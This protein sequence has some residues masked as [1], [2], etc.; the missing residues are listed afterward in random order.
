M[1]PLLPEIENNRNESLSST[2]ARC[3]IYLLSDL[4]AEVSGE[5]VKSDFSVDQESYIEKGAA[6]SLI[7]TPDRVW[8][9]NPSIYVK[10]FDY[11]NAP[12]GRKRDDTERGIGLNVSRFFKDFELFI[13]I[14]LTDNNS[15]SEPETYRRTITQCGM[16]WSF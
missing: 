1:I 3:M 13:S 4:K 7:W 14:N 2:T 16:V 8:E 11:N 5:Y 10:R 15:D 12:D 6:F 9:I